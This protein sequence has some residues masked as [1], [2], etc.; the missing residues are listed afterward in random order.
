MIYNAIVAAT[1][2]ASETFRERSLDKNDR[3]LCPFVIRMQRWFAGWLN[4]LL[5][6]RLA[7]FGRSCLSRVDCFVGSLACSRLQG[8]FLLHGT[9]EVGL[10]SRWPVSKNIIEETR[11]RLHSPVTGRIFDRLNNFTG[12]LFTRFPSIV[13]LRS[14]GTL[15]C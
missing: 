10:L 15:D 2:A 6:Y 9:V 5:V 8:P 13:S 4:L 7:L 14:H 3:V 1:V 11:L 12:T